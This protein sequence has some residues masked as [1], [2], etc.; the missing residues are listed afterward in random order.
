MTLAVSQSRHSDPTPEVRGF[1]THV[2]NNCQPEFTSPVV[3]SHV[4]ACK[5]PCVLKTDSVLAGRTLHGAARQI[6]AFP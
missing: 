4:I 5:Q 2:C 1:A 6:H 3:V